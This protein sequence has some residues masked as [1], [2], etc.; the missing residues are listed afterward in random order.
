[1]KNIQKKSKMTPMELK[2]VTRVRIEKIEERVAQEPQINPEVNHFFSK[3][4]YAREMKLNKG[5]L[6][7]GKIHKHKNLNIVSKG[8]LQFISVDGMFIVE[9]PHTFVAEPGAKRVIVAL[10]DST[11]TTIHGTSET[12]LGKIEEQFIAKDYDQVDGMTEEE[13]NLIK[14]ARK[15]L[16]LL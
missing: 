6:I 15:C 8:K 2:A 12:D 3:D 14:E 4:V 1:M 13:Y 5:D 16:G 7:V 11:W 10:E 9:A